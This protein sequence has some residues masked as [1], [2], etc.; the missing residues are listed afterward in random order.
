MGIFIRPIIIIT[1]KIVLFSESAYLHYTR[2]DFDVV[3]LDIGHVN[4]GGRTKVNI[5]DGCYQTFIF[6]LSL[7]S[8]LYKIMFILAICLDLYDF[9]N[10]T[11][12][13]EIFFTYLL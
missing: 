7:C 2:V 3:M 10:Q 4:E 12:A 11:L 5:N 13:C 1:N 6:S 8:L 9:K